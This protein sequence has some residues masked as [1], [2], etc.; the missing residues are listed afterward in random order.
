VD[1]KRLLIVSHYSLFDQGLR[2]AL[3]Q[4]PD[5]EVVGVA[6]DLEEAHTQARAQNPDVLL[7]IAG[8]DIVHDSAFR[9][10]EEISPS[11]IRISPT[12]GSM[13][14][15]RR[16]QVDKASLDDLMTAI[17]T[18]AIQLTVEEQDDLEPPQALPKETHGY[19]TR[20]RRDGMKHIIIV[21]VLVAIVTVLMIL[22]LSSIQLLPTIAS[23][24][25]VLID[26]LFGLQ[27]VIIA[28]LFSLIIVFVLYSVVVFRRRPGEAEDGP[29]IRG[30]TKLEIVWTAIPLITVLS[31]GVI[32]ARQL[33]VISTPTADEL[34]VD[35][36]ATSF[37]W[38]FDY[39]DY[40]I[41]SPVLN[42]PR[43]RQVA[44]RITSVDTDVIHSF[45]VPEFRVKQDA[46][47]G[48][49]HT[50]R[51]TPSHVGQYKVR[52][53]E[54]CGVG[55]AYM[56]ADVNVMEPADFEA[57]V[58]TQEAPPETAGAEP[59]SEVSGAEVTGAE[60]GAEIAQSQGCK[61]CHSADGSQLVGPTWQG[62]FGTEEAL[63]DGSSVL[64][65]EEY[66]RNSILEPADQITQGF[67]NVMPATYKDTL[68]EE[69]IDALVDYI[70]SLGA[71]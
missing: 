45:W 1:P 53:A 12:D 36:I 59:G 7:L 10:L 16:E 6:R 68:T 69:E 51:I 50:L 38:S 61:G 52:C 58:A 8:P 4:Q 57:W 15:Y 20:R 11:I 64:V 2:A 26:N 23:E 41:S 18:T 27:L 54:L 17:Q 33:R 22:A 66:V 71:R 65:D 30:N 48:Q 42:V 70:K 13:Q 44:F 31:L 40:G 25:G 37:A 9:L 14:V 47:P 5:I 21:A 19:P 49:I 3:N 67:P 28:F 34:V 63:E 35:V 32:G 24:E 62:L 60:L 56:L 43:G 46:V 55:H 29:N 39:P